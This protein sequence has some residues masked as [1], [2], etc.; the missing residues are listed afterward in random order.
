MCGSI[1]SKDFSTTNLIQHLKTCHATEYN[2]FL[3]VTTEKKKAEQEKAEPKQISLLKALKH[4]QKFG[5]GDA[6]AKEITNRLVEFMALDD[7]RRRRR[8]QKILDSI[9]SL[10]A[11]SLV[12]HCLAESL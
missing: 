10:N 6:R 4:S 12:T 7:Q 11:W 5:S 9:I 1:T 3:K 2:N 8:L